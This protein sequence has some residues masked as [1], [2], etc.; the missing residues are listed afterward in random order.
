MLPLHPRRAPAAHSRG[1]LC[2]EGFVT[3]WFSP[4]DAPLPSRC[5][6]LPFRAARRRC[7]RSGPGE[8]RPAPRCDSASRTRAR[9]AGHGHRSRARARP[10]PLP[11]RGASPAR[12]ERANPGHQHHRDCRSRTKKAFP[13]RTAG[14]ELPLQPE[15]RLVSL[16]QC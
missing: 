8:P 16:G 12:Q 11:E 4:L 2:R 10:A 13:H 7:G 3:P 1:R 5:A 15:D 6:F 9:P 14:S